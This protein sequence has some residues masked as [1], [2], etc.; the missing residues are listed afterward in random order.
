MLRH[1]PRGKKA[2]NASNINRIG[3]RVSLHNI[4]LALQIVQVDLSVVAV[5]ND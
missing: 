3:R 5:V 4:V 1:Y 2:L